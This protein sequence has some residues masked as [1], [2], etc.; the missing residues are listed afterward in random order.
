MKTHLLPSLKLSLMCLVL[1][2]GLYSLLIWGVAVVAGPN[3]GKT[4]FISKNGK[5]IGAENI[6]QSFSQDKYFW[7]RPSAVGYNA[8]G[9]AGSNKGPTNA[10]YLL[11]VQ[12]RI[13]TFLVHNP[14]VN[15]A[16]I[17]SDMV[18]ASG[19]GL[20][21]HISPQGA[22]IQIERISKTRN[23]DKAKVATLVQQYTE[24]PFM[25][26]FGIPRINVLKL[27]LALDQL[28]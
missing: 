9:S 6:G 17:P 26:I 25:G 19:S 13:D 4:E 28:K 21:P 8:A 18:C 12:S 22:K 1:F 14:G 27:N 11:V 7:G 23:I 2:V 24:G 5:L 20:D 16:D 3:N 10:D 15:K